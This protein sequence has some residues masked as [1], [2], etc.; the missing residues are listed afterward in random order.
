MDGKILKQTRKQKKIS[1]RE[2]AKASGLHKNTINGIEN[3]TGNPSIQTAE[4][5]L[6]A[7]GLKLVVAI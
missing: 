3:N 6:D 2:L 1:I 5:Y 7:I 4:K